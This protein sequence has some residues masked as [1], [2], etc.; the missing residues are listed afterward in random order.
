MD[1]T[2]SIVIHPK[3]PIIK[4]FRSFKNKLYNKIGVYGSC[5]SV[6]HIT[7]SEFKA[8]DQ[9]LKYIIEKL[10]II[11]QNEECFDTI[12]DK[13]IYSDRSKSIIILPCE[14]GN[15]NFKKLLRNV[16]QKIK[17][18]NSKSNAHL[19]IG[20]K[21]THDQLLKSMDL[22]SDVRFDF[23]CNQIALRKFN[24]NIRQ[25]EIIQIFPLS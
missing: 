4:L 7:I 18:Y 3:D 8:T 6:A 24:Q 1:K 2:Y 11:A 25:F 12:F 17:G 10:R 5:D 21:L 9:E 22:F 23:H 14:Q 20:R 13:V 16:R 15:E 19:T